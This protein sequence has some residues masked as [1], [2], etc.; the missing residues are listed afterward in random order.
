[1]NKK[2]KSALVAIG[3]MLA[4][5]ACAADVN[6]STTR[7]KLRA[8]GEW[9]S[10]CEDAGYEQNNCLIHLTRPSG[11]KGRSGEEYIVPDVAGKNTILTR[12]GVLM[13][14][15]IN[16]QIATLETDDGD[17]TVVT[18]KS[19]A[20]C[21]TFAAHGAV[22][23]SMDSIFAIDSFVRVT[24]DNLNAKA[25]ID[26][27]STIAGENALVFKQKGGG[28]IGAYKVDLPR[29][30]GIWVACRHAN[31]KMLKASTKAFFST[32]LS[33]ARRY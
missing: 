8:F 24:T 6:A 18:L 5:S 13:S 20:R 23:K 17:Q 4:G 2:Q 16:K 9:E 7:N 30:A 29:N 22:Y 21:T 31:E 26:F 12:S 25:L 11:R 3:L 32:I 28:L 15:L 10:L 33:S 27:D 14:P 1:M 19:G